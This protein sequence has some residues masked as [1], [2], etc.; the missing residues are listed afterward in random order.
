MRAYHL[1]AALLLLILSAGTGILPQVSQ[2]TPSLDAQI[3]QMLMV[4][5]R[6]TSL[7]ENAPI[8]T[9]LQEINLGG[10]VLFDYDVPSQSFPRNIVSFEQTQALI[11][12]LQSTAP[13]PLLVAIDAEGGRINRLKPKYGFLDIPSA[14][15]LGKAGLE[16]C[17]LHYRRLAD[18]LSRLGINLNLAPVIDLNLNPENPVIGALERSFSAHPQ[19]VSERA[20]VFI[21]THRSA[22]VIT[23]L[24]HFPG[25]G[26]SLNDSHLGLVD[27]TST[28]QDI[29]LRP[30]QD[31]IRTQKADVIMTAHIMRRDLDPHYPAT[32][33]PAILKTL[34]RERLGFRGV[35]ISD[36]MQMGA[37]SRNFGLKEAL[38]QAVL[39]GC[40]ILALANNGQVYDEHAAVK[41]HRILKQ[42][43][44]ENRIP[45][46][47][48]SESYTRIR[49]LKKKYG[50]LR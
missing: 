7:D 13:T 45:L 30:F 44:L 50:L 10:V 38:V 39:A 48:I 28:Y 41:A 6:G 35:L 17:R 1:V 8:L 21:D 12:R 37:I 26:S 11:R 27:V 46:S 3:G 18:Q 32:L 4:G 5:F 23:S 47:R 33:S 19:I 16:Q 25:H 24:K 2:D 42:A 14:Q 15:T 9:V 36:D 31:L 29:E 40:D 49:K 20:A 34:L 43:V 22:G